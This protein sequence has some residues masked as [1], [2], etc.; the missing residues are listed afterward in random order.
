MPPTNSVDTLDHLT[1]T[2]GRPRRRGLLKVRETL[3]RW[4][5]LGSAI[6]SVVTTVAII[7]VL[8]SETLSFFSV[9]TSPVR[10][11]QLG[12][13]VLSQQVERLK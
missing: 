10:A 1:R 6:F 12:Y 3:I 11:E 8:A 4:G 13:R 5:L 7:V 9:N 2:A